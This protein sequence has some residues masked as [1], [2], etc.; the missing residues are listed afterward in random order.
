M[1]IRCYSETPA[2][3]LQKD[4]FS[5]FLNLRCQPAFR[6]QLTG[7]K[8]MICTMKGY[9]ATSALSLKLGLNVQE[10]S[11]RWEMVGAELPAL[12]SKCNGWWVPDTLSALM[13]RMGHGG[14]QELLGVRALESD[15][16]KP[17]HSP[18][19]YLLSSGNTLVTVFSLFYVLPTE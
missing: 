18:E 4:G 19:T 16:L 14:D 3:D 9:G 11:Q 7:I 1:S 10:N 15:H 17:T 5:F 12:W 6:K 2:R 8:I 13:E